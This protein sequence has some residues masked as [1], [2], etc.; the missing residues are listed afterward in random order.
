MRALVIT[1]DVARFAAAAAWQF[2]SGAAMS[3]ARGAARGVLC[4]ALS[5]ASPASP[6]ASP[7]AS[8]LRSVGGAGA[9][10]VA[11]LRAEATYLAG[12]I[13][14]ASLAMSAVAEGRDA[15]LHRGAALVSLR[16][17]ASDDAEAGA[18]AGAGEGEAS[19]ASAAA[20]ASG[21]GSSSGVAAGRL[22]RRLPP[23]GS[24]FDLP[25]SGGPHLVAFPFGAVVLFG[26]HED[27]AAIRRRALSACRDFAEDS[28]PIAAAAAAAA[29]AGRDAYDRFAP[30]STHAARWAGRA[31][32]GSG[33]VGA[34]SKVGAAARGAGFGSAG[35]LSSA[36]DASASSLPVAFPFT[37]EYGVS[38]DPSLSHPSVHLP[39]S[40]S[41]RSLDARR[42]LVIAHVLAQSV[43]LDACASHVQ[44]ALATF[45][46]MNEEMLATGSTG[47]VD[48]HGLVALV[49]EN[50][51]VLAD[52]V[53]RL[54]LRERYDVAWKHAEYG[55]LWDFLRHELE[56]EARFDAVDAKLQLVQDNLKYLLELLQNQKSNS[57]EWI[58]IALIALEI[59]MNL[60]KV[61]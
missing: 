9:P 4:R 12:S 27:L 39:D 7:A 57:L 37:E 56:I 14:T 21:S 19:A 34:G 51:L 31:R 2:G 45:E 41:A 49:A 43:A 3:G 58:I 32:G 54:G 33:G 44:R 25:L 52:V 11:H 22:P 35:F 6:Q 24:P 53:N 30:T 20:A 47:S 55:E 1:R 23:I 29:A 38:L 26:S 17:W 8:P 40:I 18:G 48:K 50:N 60:L 28:G 61:F 5:S 15:L 16:G 10:A 42:A 59:A 46:A 13:D 36:S